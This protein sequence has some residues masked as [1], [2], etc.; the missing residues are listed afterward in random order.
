M[1]NKMTEVDNKKSHIIGTPA[2]ANWRAFLENKPSL[3]AY[4]Y[5]MYTDAW[6]TGEVANGLEPYRFFNLIA[7]EMRKGRVRPAVALRYSLHIDFQT[8]FYFLRENGSISL[9]RRRDGG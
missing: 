2:Y 4:E 9:S 5:L 6:I 7:I 3:G 8:T 1:A